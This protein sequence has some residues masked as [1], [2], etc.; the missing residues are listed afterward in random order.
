MLLWA[1]LA[2]L[3]VT[4]ASK[5]EVCEEPPKWSYNGLSMMDNSQGNITLIALLTASEPFCLQQAERL[6]ALFQDL[7]SQGL[8]NIT[9]LIINQKSLL[10]DLMVDDLE[11]KVSFPVY[12]D[13][14]HDKI[15]KK[16][17]GGNQDIYIYDKCGRLTYYIPFPFSIIHPSQPVVD[18]ALR[19]TYF[20]ELCGQSCDS[21]LESGE[22]ISDY[23]RSIYQNYLKISEDE[24]NTVIINRDKIKKN[25]SN[26]DDNPAIIVEDVSDEF[27][28]ILNKTNLTIEFNV[29]DSIN[30]TLEIENITNIHDE[31][32]LNVTTEIP[33]EEVNKST[34]LNVTRVTFCEKEYQ[35]TCEFWSKSKLKHFKKCCQFKMNDHPDSH[36]TYKSFECRHVGKKRCKKMLPVIKCCLGPYDISPEP[37]ILNT[38]SLI[39]NETITKSSE[40]LDEISFS[41]TTTAP[42]QS[43]LQKLGK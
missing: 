37:D 1:T 17:E 10:A 13:N 30:T 40:H 21:I 27:N 39:K 33:K 2:I 26:L 9:F 12:Q 35:E 32:I 42:Q 4:G 28:N 22:I 20:E 18:A 43:F 31:F 29:T 38:T 5:P 16:L 3:F 24:R 11:N 19:S 36:N 25:T 34:E 41:T 23:N 15:W 7:S 14:D 8:T 6:E